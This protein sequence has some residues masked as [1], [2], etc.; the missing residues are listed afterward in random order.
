MKWAAAIVVLVLLAAASYETA[1]ALQ[2]LEIGPLPGEGRREEEQ[3]LLVAVVAQLVGAVLAASDAFA[4]RIKTAA[5]GSIIPLAAAAF[6]TARFYSFDPYYAPTLRRMSD[7]GLVAPWWVFTLVACSL[8]AAA[9]TRARPRVGF[10]V[11]AV[12]LPLCA[13]TAFAM[14]LGH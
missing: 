2:W 13:L 6:M 12:V 14:G 5:T 11:V 9:L 3:A 8:L 4:P 7:G 10:G 1:I